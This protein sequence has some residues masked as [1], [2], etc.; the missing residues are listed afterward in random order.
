[1]AAKSSWRADKINM[2]DNQRGN[3][4]KIL[5]YGDENFDHAIN[6]TIATF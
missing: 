5:L 4:T 1:M 3:W 2:A 6:K